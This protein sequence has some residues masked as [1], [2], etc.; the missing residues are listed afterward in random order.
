M[1][2]LHTVTPYGLNDKCNGKY[3]TTRS[4]TDCTAQLF[5]KLDVKRHS[6]GTGKIALTQPPVDLQIFVDDLLAHPPGSEKLTFVRRKVNSIKKRLLPSLGFQIATMLHSENGLNRQYLEIIEDLVKHRTLLFRSP[7]IEKRKVP[8]NIVK[9]YF[10]DKGIEKIG[11]PKILRDNYVQSCIPAHIQNKDP[12]MICYKYKAPIAPKIF[13][14]AQVCDEITTDLA[15]FPCSC[16]RSP[17]MDPHHK[18]VVTGDLNIV[19]NQKLRSLMMKGPNYREPEPENYDKNLKEIKTA[20]ISYT[21]SWANKSQINED[22]L[23]SWQNAVFKAVEHRIVMLKSRPTT[24]RK[25]VL[26]QPTVKRALRNLQT[27]YVLM[28]TDKAS[29]NI[30]VVCKRFYVEK[31][32]KE[33]PLLP[34]GKNNGTYQLIAQTMDE[35]VDTHKE[36]LLGLNQKYGLP[37][38]H[39]RLPFVYWISK[40]HKNPSKQRF[41]AGSRYCTTKC[42]SQDITKCLELVAMQHKK[43]CQAILN[44]TGTQRCWV[45]NNTRGILNLIQKCNEK[46][47]NNIATYDFSTLYTTIPLKE[48]K[49]QIGWTV[50]KAFHGSGK[51]FINIYHSSARWSNKQCSPNSKVTQIDQSK[52]MEM[53]VFLIDNIF[54]TCGKYVFR[55][56]IGIPMGTDCAP[57]LANLF[58]YAYEFQYLE[59]LAKQRSFNTLE[60]FKKTARFLDDLFIANGNGILDE[61]APYIYPKCLTLKLENPDNDQQCTFLDLQLKIQSGKIHYELYDKRDDF[62]FPIVKYP[63]LSGNICSS[64]AYGVFIGQLLRI[65]IACETYPCFLD[66]ART[67]TKILLQQSFKLRTLKYKLKVFFER[68]YCEIQNF[69]KSL[70]EISSDLFT[71]L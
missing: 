26:T 2:E 40:Q 20:I 10:R 59:K 35:V 33:L 56:I 36:E 63:D 5:H 55:Q 49:E 43:Y 31:I 57:F 28:P 17:F 47:V 3:W 52:L 41:I 64:N 39:Q 15:S 45:A 9:L 23:T 30:T 71:D 8:P 34:G 25:K 53:I 61:H 50:S 1:R 14:Y 65:A 37:E 13:N 6:R 51:K 27:N 16:E 7:Q 18:H 48:L 58:L 38:R 70:E 42:L 67:L 29:N 11:L 69:G 21:K 12:P 19:K 32:L 4:T 62:P 24:H 68:H 66:R 22:E 60:R 54:V 44:Y 46:T